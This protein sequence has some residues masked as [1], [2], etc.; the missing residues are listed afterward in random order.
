VAAHERSL[1]SA[2]FSSVLQ[3]SCIRMQ[4]N[5]CGHIY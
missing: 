4:L 5:E 2:A 3:P 1:V